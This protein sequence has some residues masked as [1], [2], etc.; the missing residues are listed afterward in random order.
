MLYLEA[1]KVFKRK[2]VWLVV[3][4]IF[5]FVLLMEGAHDIYF[6]TDGGYEELQQL[7]FSYEWEWFIDQFIA[8]AKFIPIFIAIAFS[9]IFTYD[10][11]CGMQEILLSTKRGRKTCTNAKVLLA[12]LA[13]NIM[14]F[15]VLFLSLL[16]MLI[17][18]RG[19]GWDTSIQMT[20]WLMDSQLN[21][22]YGILSLHTMYLSFIAINF[23]LLV[24]L[25]ASF[26]AKSPVVAMCVSLGILYIVRPDMVATFF[27]S[28][29]AN[30][31]VSLTPLNVISSYNL[32]EQMPVAVGGVTIQWITVAEVLYTLLLIGGL[33]F[34]FKVL[35]R[36][37]KY[38]AT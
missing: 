32:A 3:M 13:T 15:L 7:G 36:H 10:R 6:M 30:K 38:Y 1:Y 29:V 16:G 27:D 18:T 26:L 34:F 19:A 11:E 5:L 4:G 31:I 9:A 28:A 23:I 14:L 2:L 35:T 21:M 17:L 24:T 8:Y 25:S 33:F 37:Q 20:L 12:F 22:N